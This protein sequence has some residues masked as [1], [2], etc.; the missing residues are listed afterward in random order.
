MKKKLQKT[1]FLILFLLCFYSVSGENSET[2]VQYVTL[3]KALEL[4]MENNP[5]IIAA[6]RN[7][8][9]LARDNTGKWNTFLPNLSLNGSYSNSHN[10]DSNTWK[11]S[12][13]T[14][15]TLSFDF[16]I[17]SEMT[18][19]TLEYQKGV[20]EYGVAATDV[21]EVLEQLIATNI[22]L[23]DTVD[24]SYGGDARDIEQFS[25]AFVIVIILAVFLVFAVMA[26][27]FESLVDPFIIFF[28]IPL[29][30]IGVVAVYKL[31]GQTLSMYSIVGIVSLV[32]IVVNNGIVLVDYTNQLVDKKIPVKEACLKAGRE[33][34]QPI[35]MSTLTTVF[36]MVPMAF[37]P[38]EGAE[39]MQPI[40]IT[41]VGGLCSGAF[42]TLF[43]TPVMYSLFN[44][45]REKRFNDPMALINQ[46]E[47]LDS[48]T[49]DVKNTVI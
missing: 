17:P 43:V 23:P 7:L 12:G 44:K 42:M 26:A 28:S 18:V 21:Q 5:D 9:S 32:G 34:L 40:C 8:E 14:G 38:G 6:R 36:G 45:R 20:V 16:G 49:F 37:F 10:A 15:V 4:G 48:G 27:Q 25:G 3:E 24:L 2:T 30:L 31:T 41:I 22:V 39:S 35:L 47:E 11:W 33:R 29:L 46:L 1:F 13:S 19:K